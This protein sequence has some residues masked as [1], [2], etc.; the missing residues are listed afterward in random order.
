MYLHS[1]SKKQV[2]IPKFFSQP[3]EVWQ[4]PNKNGDSEKKVNTLNDSRIEGKKIWDKSK[5]K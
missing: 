5:Y 4:K 3:K 1:N 2:V